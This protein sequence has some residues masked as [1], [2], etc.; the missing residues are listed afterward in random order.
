MV[1]AGLCAVKTVSMCLSMHGARPFV[2]EA[3]I[4]RTKEA[5]KKYGACIAGMPSKDT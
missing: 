2:T 5:V 4:V 3:I 1:Y